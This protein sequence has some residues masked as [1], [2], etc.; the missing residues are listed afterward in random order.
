MKNYKLRKSLYAIALA[1]SLSTLTGCG[2]ELAAEEEYD[3]V[4][5]SESGLE[6]G[7]TQIIDV[8]GE[9]FK[10]IACYSCDS[11]SKREWRI[12]SDKFLYLNIHTQDLEE[13]TEV[14]IDNIH[15][16]TSIKS[17]YAV[18][19]GIIQDS[20]DDR[21][22]NSLMI[23]F[24]IGNETYYYG[25][26]AIEGSNADF[27]TGTF[28]GYNGYHR[29]EVEQKR[30]TESDY[31]ELGVYA[32]KISIVIDLLVKGPNDKEFRNISINSEFLV[33]ISDQ[34]TLDTDTEEKEYT[35]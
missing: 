15:I 11:A 7:L 8:P 24:P 3:V 31:K 34:N 10:V 22:H 2:E 5:N 1:A 12:T 25:I 27:I 32:N 35:K 19:D 4:N 14:Y 13:G 21:V 6:N 30:Y 17:K 18:M 20:M 9:D 29:G 23:G 26:N 16:D 28:Y 33:K